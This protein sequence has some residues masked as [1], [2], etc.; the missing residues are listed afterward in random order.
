MVESSRRVEVS[1]GRL[2][3]VQ[4]MSTTTTESPSMQLHLQAELTRVV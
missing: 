2:R 4:M 3:Y 1:E